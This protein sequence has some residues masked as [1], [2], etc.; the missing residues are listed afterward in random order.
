MG[1]CK[2]WKCLSWKK[3]EN[4]NPNDIKKLTAKELYDFLYNEY[5]VWKY[6]AKNRLATTRMQLQR[7]IIENRLNDL[8]KIKRELFS[9]DLENIKQGLEIASGIHGLGIAGAS[10]LLA[11]LFPEYFGAV[12]QCVVLD[13][14]R[15][16]GIKQIEWILNMNPNN[17]RLKDVKQTYNR[18]ID[19]ACK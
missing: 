4:L 8:E 6:T 19:D 11:L 12:D 5:F 17:I 13:L 16:K 7:Y 18:L 15:I 1:I 3:L 10:V 14:L 2:A 9:F